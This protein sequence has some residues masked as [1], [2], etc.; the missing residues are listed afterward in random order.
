MKADISITQMIMIEKQVKDFI[1]NNNLDINNYTIEDVSK[2]LNIEEDGQC[3]T[4]ETKLYIDDNGV[5]HITFK[6]DLSEMQKQF[7]RV[8]E[9]GHIILDDPLPATRPDGHGKSLMEQRADYAGAA[10][11]LPFEKV[12]LFLLKNNYIELY[13]KERSE[14]ILHFCEQHNIDTLVFLRRIEEVRLLL[15]NDY[16]TD[17]EN[18]AK[19]FGSLND[20]FR[21]LERLK[22]SL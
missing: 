18:L 6:K 13:E 1:S 16:Y 5:K 20:L 15:K 12:L 14:L 3:S 17:I 4:E 21:R 22:T 11:L 9:Y 7:E 19:Q 10:L 8:H 2:I